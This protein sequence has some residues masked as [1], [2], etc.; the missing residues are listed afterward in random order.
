MLQTVLLGDIDTCASSLAIAAAWI[1]CRDLKY[2]EGSPGFGILMSGVYFHNYQ[3]DPQT[4]YFLYIGELKNYGLNVFL[5]DA[6]KRLLKHPI[7][8]IAIV[9]DILE[10]YH[11]HNIMVINPVAQERFFTIRRKFSCRVPGPTFMSSVSQ[12][13][14]VIRLIDELLQ[15]QAHLYIYMYESLPEMSLDDIDGVSLLGPDSFVAHRLNNKIYQYRNFNDIV[16]IPEFAV[17]HG[18]DELE[19]TTD[20]LWPVW[21]DGIF[22]TTEFSAAGTN[23]VIAHAWQDVSA[24]FRS[25]DFHYLVSR[26]HP[27]RY[28]PTVLAVVANEGEVYVAGIAD[29]RIEGGNRFTGSTY[30]SVLPKAIQE[31]LFVITR[32]IGCR[33]G[34]EGYR[35]IFGCDYVVDDDNEILFVEV[36][37]RKQGTT[38]EFCCTL[39]QL[40]P[41][42]APMLPELEYY[43][44]V[45]NCFPD[46]FSELPAGYEGGIHWGAYNLKLTEDT[47]IQG[48]MPYCGDER[49]C[50]G[51]VAREKVSRQFIILEHI[52]ND[53]VIAAGSFLGRIVALG[54]DHESVQEGLLQGKR[55]LKTTIAKGLNRHAEPLKTKE[56]Q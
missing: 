21:T 7:D 33:L 56:Y 17:C 54:Q 53:F 32:R 23:S 22:V 6:L 28:D 9:P 48:F 30:P 40:L 2:S 45:K 46:A 52:G 24:K 19:A 1:A 35:G 8:F 27:H 11:Y 55:M 20:K 36:N 39:E 4:E 26:Y 10:Q 15:R 50:F 12:N 47:C 14:H 44:V 51:R 38:L 42:G 31:R 16:P 41:V 37:A 3:I 25:G 34:K 49:Q 18:L 13:P 29:Q 43:A 5:K